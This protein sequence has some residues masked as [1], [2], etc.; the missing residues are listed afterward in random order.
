[1]MDGTLET[2][3][4]RPA[5]RF[6]RPLAHSV[7]RVWRAVSGPAELER[8]FPAAVEWTPAAGETLE[9]GGMTG[10]VTEVEA[11]NRLAWTFNGERYS[12]RPGLT[13]RWLPTRLHPRLRR[14]HAR[15]ADRDRLG[16]LLLPARAPPRR[17]LPL[18]GGRA[19]ALGRGPRALRGAPRGRPR[20]GPA[21]HR[22]P[23]RVIR[24]R[25]GAAGPS[26]PNPRRHRRPSRRSPQPLVVGV[27][28]EVVAQEGGSVVESRLGSRQL[29]AQVL[30]QAALVERRPQ[31]RPPPPAARRRPRAGPGA[32]DR[33]SP[34]RRARAPG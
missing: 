16:G 2:V 32:W 11:P 21:L 14:P 15:R 17:R 19:R 22:R 5:L 13:R 26:H 33:R 24:A 7:E 30:R 18:R 9:A 20:S 3:D 34:S 27:D 1:M 10:E 23:P 28:L 6:E 12:L 29:R 25:P 4:G 8:W 31:S